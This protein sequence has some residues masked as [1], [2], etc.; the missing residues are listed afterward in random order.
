MV[1]AKIQTVKGR[2]TRIV[3]SGKMCYNLSC[4]TNCSI[5]IYGGLTMFIFIAILFI[6]CGILLLLKTKK[7]PKEQGLHIITGAGA[8]VLIILGVI[9]TYCILSGKIVLPLH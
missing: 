1:T 5:R 9:L 4:Q 2:R 7:M 3:F 8:I 6:I